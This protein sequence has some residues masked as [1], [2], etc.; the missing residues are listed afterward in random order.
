[1][2]RLSCIKE[3]EFKWIQSAKYKLNPQIVEL[4]YKEG[5]AVALV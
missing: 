3:C 5:V 4:G 1:M 2:L